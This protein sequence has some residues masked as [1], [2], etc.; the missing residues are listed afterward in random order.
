MYCYSSFIHS[1]LLLLLPYFCLSQIGELKRELADV[2]NSYR[3][4]G[5]HLSTATSALEAAEK[6]T[7]RLKDDLNAVRSNANTHLDSFRAKSAECSKLTELIKRGES[8]GDSMRDEIV[9][10]EAEVTTWMVVN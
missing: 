7:T 8:L 1:L 6:R 9:K 3:E 2:T 5:V 10:L 4:Q